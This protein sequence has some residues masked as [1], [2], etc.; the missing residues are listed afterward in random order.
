MGNATLKMR[1]FSGTNFTFDEQLALCGG[2]I[3][4]FM[5]KSSLWIDP[6]LQQECEE[7][8]GLSMLV[9]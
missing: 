3:K 5:S 1:I 7:N 9:A 6:Q 2:K 4:S 8:S